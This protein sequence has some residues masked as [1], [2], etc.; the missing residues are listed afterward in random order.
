MEP[1][2]F[3]KFKAWKNA[4]EAK[5]IIRHA[6]NLYKKRNNYSTLSKRC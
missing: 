1:H 4:E 6:I 3:V 5:K 2:R